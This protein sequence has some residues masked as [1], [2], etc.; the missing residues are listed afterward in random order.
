MRVTKQ[1]NFWPYQVRRLLELFTAEQI[2]EVISATPERVRQYATGRV[3]PEPI[4]QRDLLRMLTV[5]CDRATDAPRLPPPRI[6]SENRVR[7]ASP[8][9]PPP[10]PQRGV[11]ED[12]IVPDGE[13]WFKV[14][15]S[16]GKVGTVRFPIELTDPQF[17]ENLWRRLDARDPV[18]LRSVK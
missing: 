3:R 16:N 12:E 5:H 7:E 18:Q 13:R 10:K 8:P 11:F 15:L 2:G 17:T 4:T 6:V 14:V 9:P 1:K